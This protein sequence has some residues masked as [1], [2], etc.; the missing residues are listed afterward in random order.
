MPESMLVEEKRVILV[1]VVLQKREA[2]FCGLA[3][4]TECFT[5]LDFWLFGYQPETEVCHQFGSVIKR[6]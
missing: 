3:I 2:Q 6:K 4:Q 5:S 1:V